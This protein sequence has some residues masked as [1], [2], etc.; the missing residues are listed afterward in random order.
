MHGAASAACHFS[1]SFAEFVGR[2]CPI[3]LLPIV[4]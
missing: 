2:F 4:P 3:L 1:M